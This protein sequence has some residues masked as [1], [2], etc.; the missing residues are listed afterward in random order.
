MNSV[1]RIAMRT[2]NN[3][4]VALYRR[5][6]GR[7]GGKGGGGVRV[8]LLTV[9][10][11]RTGLP[12]TT[13]VGYFDHEGGYLV[14][15][16][17]GGLPEDPQWFKNLRKAST[18]S[19]Q[20]GHDVQEVAVRVLPREERDRVWREVVLVHQPRFARYETKTSRSIPLALLTSREVSGRHTG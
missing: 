4:G 11:R 14:V 3:V 13:P 17:A 10:G 16:S 1:M 5:S 8:L 2:G 6:G 18:A 19:I 12:R 15:G 9:A 7:I 20:I